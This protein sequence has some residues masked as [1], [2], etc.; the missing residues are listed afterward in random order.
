VNITVTPTATVAV[1]LAANALSIGGTTQATASPKDGGGTALTNRT[2][3]N[4]SSSNATVATINQATGV[5]TAVSAGVTTISATIEG[6][7]G[8]AQL[9]VCQA[10]LAPPAA[11]VTTVFVSATAGNDATGSGNCAAPYKTIS[12]AVVGTTNGAVIRAAPGTYNTAL[13]ETF[14]INL[15]AGVSLIGD[16]ANR[17]Q[18]TTG[19][20]II[21][22]G[23]LAFAGQDCGTYRTT[24]YAGA[25]STIAGFELTNPVNLTVRMTLVVRTDGVTIRNN[26]VTGLTS[27]E[28]AIYVC[29]NSVNQVITGNRIVNNLGVGLGFIGGGAGSRVENNIITGNDYGVEFDS[30]G[31]DLGGGAKGSIGGNVISCNT[32]NDLWTNDTITISAMNNFW[33]H[34]PLSG[35]DVFNG[36]GATIIT[37]GARLATP[38]CN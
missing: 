13:G 31:G 19:T 5:V 3:S 30:P 22:D 2:V 23:L 10:G 29:N 38:V 9:A 18:G 16:E 4:W 24:V 12:K 1:G 28:S 11:G 25:N 15:P 35:N 21:G 34:I 37:T 32:I 36:S 6:V 26:T 14:P 8:T 20:K 17:G 33:D 27:G 7:I